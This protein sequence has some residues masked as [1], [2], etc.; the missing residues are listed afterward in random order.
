MFCYGFLHMD[1]P[2]LA[3]QQKVIFT[4]SVVTLDAVKRTCQ[5]QWLTVGDSKKESKEFVLLSCH[6]N[7]ADET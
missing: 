4:I 7:D 1:T 2:V 6:D 3:D 5:K